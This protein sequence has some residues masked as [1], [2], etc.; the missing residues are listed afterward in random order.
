MGQPALKNVQ[1]NPQSTQFVHLDG[2]I[3]LVIYSVILETISS[4]S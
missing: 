4:L 2:E 1:N 3:N